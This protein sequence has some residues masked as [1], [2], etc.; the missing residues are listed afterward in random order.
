MSAPLSNKRLAMSAWLYAAALC[1]GIVRYLPAQGEF[2]RHAATL[3]DAQ[4]HTLEGEKCDIT[5]V[6]RH[7]F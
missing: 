3:L 7:R 4:I 2:G 6:V 1:S 5:I